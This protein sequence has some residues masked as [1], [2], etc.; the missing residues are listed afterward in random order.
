MNTWLQ[1]ILY[2]GILL[3]LVKPL[4]A[5]M[6]KV[7]QSERLFLDTV[8]GPV[9]RFL[10]RLSGIDPRS[11]MTWKTY[12]VAMLLF[13]I[14]GLITVYLFQRLQGFLPLNP[15]GF[16]AVSPD[17]AWNTAVSFASNTN[18]QG[19]GSETTMSYL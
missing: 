2:F 6:A 5:Y 9:E 8:L 3:L 11:E 13:N 4:G 12:A 1:L 15:Q 18:W 14:F 17:S 10:Y 16:G 7:Y 19:Y